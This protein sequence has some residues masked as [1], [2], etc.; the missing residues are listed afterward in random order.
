[1]LLPGR[2]NNGVA[3]IPV[4]AAKGTSSSGLGRKSRK[5]NGKKKSKR[6]APNWKGKIG[7]AQ[8]H[9]MKDMLMR[10]LQSDFI[11]KIKE[12]KRFGKWW[13]KSKKFRKSIR[14]LKKNPRKVLAPIA[15]QQEAIERL[16][17][18]KLLLLLP[19]FLM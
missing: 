10:A 2:D 14:A 3:L 19:T 1:M 18:S 4:V 7:K 15:K 11:S 12:H 16:G 13:K 8:G 5:K 17:P 9:A 6:D